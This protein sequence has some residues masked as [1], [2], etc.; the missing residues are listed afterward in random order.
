MYLVNVGI[1]PHGNLIW[2][3]SRDRDIQTPNGNHSPASKP[4]NQEA[5][6]YIF[7]THT[8]MKL[9]HRFKNIGCRN[10]H[11][12]TRRTN[13]YMYIARRPKSSGQ[14][15]IGCLLV[16]LEVGAVEENILRV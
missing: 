16:L 10:L 5:P 2:L 13:L 11:K 15:G 6:Y 12:G 8:V 14:T 4:M 9:W 7:P 1:L 3:E